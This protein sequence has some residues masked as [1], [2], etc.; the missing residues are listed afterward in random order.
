MFV[1]NYNIQIKLNYEK[2]N[3]LIVPSQERKLFKISILC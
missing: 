2:A 1:M 3:L